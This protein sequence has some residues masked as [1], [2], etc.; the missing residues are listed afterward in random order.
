ML[1]PRDHL[2]KY[3]PK[4]VSISIPIDKIREVIGSGGKIVQKICA[5]FDVKIDIEE[6]G[7]VFIMGLFLQCLQLLA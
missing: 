7:K 1:A 2:S 6:D 5:E 3:A 4:V